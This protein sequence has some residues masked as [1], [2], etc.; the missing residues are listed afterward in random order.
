MR[1]LEMG[2]IQMRKRGPRKDTDTKSQF[3]HLGKGRAVIPEFYLTA[4]KAPTWFSSLSWV[5]SF[6]EQNIPIS[7]VSYLDKVSFLQPLKMIA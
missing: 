5:I 1:F 2:R 3:T 6:Q 4:L 7:H